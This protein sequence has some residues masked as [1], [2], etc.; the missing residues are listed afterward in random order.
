MALQQ[1]PLHRLLNRL[2]LVVHLELAVDVFDVFAR[3]ISAMRW[4]SSAIAIV[5]IGFGIRLQTWG[6]LPSP[7]IHKP[8]YLPSMFAESLIRHCLRRH[9]SMWSCRFLRKTHIQIIIRSRSSMVELSVV[10]RL[11]V[12]SNPTWSAQKQYFS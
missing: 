12:G 5:I 1:P 6:G 9:W 4:L 2:D 3:G 10:N 11:V 7:C 8:A